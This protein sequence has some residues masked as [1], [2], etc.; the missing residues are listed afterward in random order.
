M[1][2]INATANSKNIQCPCAVHAKPF[3]YIGIMYWVENSVLQLDARSELRNMTDQ[4]PGVNRSK[5]LRY[6][7]NQK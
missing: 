3:A 7:H 5:D 1:T 6:F 4:A 2:D